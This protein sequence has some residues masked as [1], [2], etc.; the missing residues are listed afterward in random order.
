[1]LRCWRINVREQQ[2]KNGFIEGESSMRN[3]AIEEYNKQYNWPVVSII[4]DWNEDRSD[5]NLIVYYQDKSE[6]PR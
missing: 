1:M 5:L 6:Y 4:E 3:R 2:L